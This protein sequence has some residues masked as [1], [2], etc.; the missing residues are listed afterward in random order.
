MLDASSS[1]T[2][3]P[4]LSSNSLGKALER[5]Q[6]SGGDLNH[7]VLPDT[8]AVSS[9]RLGEEPTCPPRMMDTKP[10]L[11]P[12]LAE[13]SL[14][15]LLTWHAKERRYDGF[16]L[17]TAHFYKLRFVNDIV[18]TFNKPYV[19]RFGLKELDYLDKEIA[20]MSRL[21]VIEKFNGVPKCV[22]N[23]LLAPKPGSDKLR[24]CFDPKHTL[25]P[26]IELFRYSLPYVPSVLPDFIRR[27]KY[28]VRLDL[29]AA[30]W[31]VPVHPDSRPY[32]CFQYRNVMYTWNVM[33]F[34]PKDAVSVF[35]CWMERVFAN[36]TCTDIIYLDD[37]LIGGTTSDE[38]ISKMS[39]C[40]SILKHNGL[41]L[42]IKKSSLEPSTRDVYCG[43]EFDLESK[44]Y[45]VPY[46]KVESYHKVLESPSLAKCRTLVNSLQFYQS[47]FPTYLHA[48]IPHLISTPGYVF[49]KDDVSCVS[50]R[51]LRLHVRTFGF[52]LF[53]FTDAS[54]RG[55]GAALYEGDKLIGFANRT[56]RPHELSYG[57]TDRE[58][59]AIR[60]AFTKLE[61]LIAGDH[62]LVFTDHKAIVDLFKKPLLQVESR[63]QRNWLSLLQFNNLDVH[64]VS[65]KD[66]NIS[67]LDQLR[68][69]DYLSRL[70]VDK[71]S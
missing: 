19:S 5:G 28:C 33:P 70:D 67:G 3:A 37:I 69:A 58:L 30:Y 35:Q 9:T 29:K 46:S 24:F 42:N 56:L 60:F 57:I 40:L 48:H 50:L 16:R 15:N 34:G 25:N 6:S 59:L 7:P 61:P 54:S 22:S 4:S 51:P 65:G 41:S 14:S 55:L 47:F 32:M 11:S 64:F 21:N 43:F 66:L 45:T 31:R 26:H 68:L 20:E 17:N 39:R 2:T 38:V 13:G 10:R 71:Y 63:R 36:E 49:K 44:S 52:P 23:I 18:P 53:L 62:V 8:S 27:Y 12:K 1:T